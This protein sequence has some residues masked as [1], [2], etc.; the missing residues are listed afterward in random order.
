MPRLSNTLLRHARHLHP[1]LPSLLRPCRDLNSARNELR[2]LVEHAISSSNDAETKH[3]RHGSRQRLRQLVRQRERGKPL[4]YILG[5]QPF[6][7]LDI[8]CRAGVLIPRS[9]ACIIPPLQHGICLLTYT[10]TRPETESLT[11]HLANLLPGLSYLPGRP[12][13][14]LRILDL[15]TGTGC[16]PILLHYLLS[17]KIND[18]QLC[19]V[20]VSVNATALARQNL[21]HNIRLGHLGLSAQEQI[22][23]VQDDIFEDNAKEWRKSTWDIVISNPPYISPDGFSKTSS[24]SVRNFEPR[25]ALVPRHDRIGLD[26]S[27]S[28][29]EIGDMFYPRLLQIAQQVGSQVLLMEVAD[30]GQARRVAEMVVR[31]GTWTG[32]E[33]WRDYPAQGEQVSNEVVEIAGREVRVR[34]KGHGRAVLAWRNGG[35]KLAGKR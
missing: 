15:C 5:S 25:I 17:S 9:A 24:R 16:I 10:N 33:I 1:L 13:Q 20:D 30:M 14:R 2:W 19:G 27:L 7:D 21:Q 4:Q 29:H 23:F 11:V 8:L 22:H 26:T 6:G 3:A 28:D 12:P 31:I 32:C 34:G 35:E 18:I